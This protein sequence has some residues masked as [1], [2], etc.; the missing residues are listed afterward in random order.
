MVPIMVSL[1]LL[2]SLSL[3][4]LPSSQEEGETVHPGDFLS[5]HLLLR[6][7]RHHLLGTTQESLR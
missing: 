7:H 4:F 3:S 1:S 6:V 2:L 5:D